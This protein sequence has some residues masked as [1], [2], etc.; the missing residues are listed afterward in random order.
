MSNS[1]DELRIHEILVNLEAGKNIL[2]SPDIVAI[3]Q[4]CSEFLNGTMYSNDLE[5]IREIL[6]ISNILYNNTDMDILPLEDGIYDLVV[7]KYNKLTGGK[8][9]VGAPPTNNLKLNTKDLRNIAENK[10]MGIDA[11]IAIPEDKQTYAANILFN[12]YP[13][14]EEDF[15]VDTSDHTV[16]NKLVRDTTPSYPELIGTLDKCKFVSMYDAINSGVKEDDESVIAFDRDFLTPT[17]P[18]AEQSAYQRTGLAKPE[19]ILELKYDGVSVEAE[20]QGDTIVFANSRGD[21][22]NQQATDY[23]GIFGGKKFIRA[24][25]MDPN[26]KFGM[27]FEAII[28]YSNLMKLE[29]MFGIKYKNPRVAVSGLLANAN[30]TMYRDFITLVPIKTSGIRFESVAQEIDWMNQYYSS[31][32]EMRYVLIR[33]NYYE[34]VDQIKQFTEEAEYMRTSMNFAYDG[35]V[36]SYTD[37]NMKQILGR[38]NSVDKWSIAIK[39][40]AKAKNTYFMKYEFSVGQDGRI[41][42]IGYFAPVEFFGTTHDKTTVH[43]YKRFMELGLREGSIVNIKYNND[44]IC[45]LTKPDISYNARIDREQPP[46]PFPEYCPSCGQEITF[47][48]SGDS[49][50]CTNPYCPEKVLAR[51]SGMLKKL[52]VKDFGRAQLTKLQV[53]NLTSFLH[54]QE[55]KAIELLGEVNG[56]KLM[57]RIQDL[58]TKSIYDYQIVGA[59]GFNGVSQSRWEK[60]LQHIRLERI[61]KANAKDL[62][63]M[64]YNIP[65]MGRTIAES[66]VYERSTIMKEDMETILSMSNVIQTYGQKQALPEVRFSGVRDKQLEQEFNSHGFSADGDKSVTKNTMFLIVPYD[67]FTSSKVEK[68]NKMIMQGKSKCMIM[69]PQTAYAY[70]QNLSGN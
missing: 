27:K 33:G 31:G 18:Y 43:S 48:E 57:S 65:G 32:V 26:L 6:V 51:V 55:N 69:N 42:P 28:T 62:F 68:V 10:S 63:D 36:V 47:S 39:F 67:G 25:G 19:M 2:T 60:I 59:I 9:P 20:I 12:K 22:A 38:K 4:I 21:T 64:I 7:V 40:N 3:N 24:K 29:Q 56:R 66:I 50:W 49:A 58:K 35:V 46:I 54:I 53:T 61:V 70:L 37:P 11:M 13:V 30:A 14:R 1:K 17:Y 15:I 45:Y 34:L 5:T 8:A 41:T 16:A 23:T 52:G 44:V